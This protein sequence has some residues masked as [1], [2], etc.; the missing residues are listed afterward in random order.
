MIRLYALPISSYSAKVRICLRA[1]GLAFEEVAPPGGY[2]SEDYTALVPVSTIPAIDHDGFVVWDSEA[3]VEYLEEAFP[4]PAML[5]AD[6][7]HRAFARALARFHDTRLEPN[8]RALFPHVAPEN[9]DPERVATSVAMIE[10]RLKQLSA[11][12][13][14]A[15][16]VPGEHLMLCDCGFAISFVLLERLGAAIGFDAP[17]VSSISGYRDRMARHPAVAEVLASYEPAITD[18]ARSRGA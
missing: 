7:Q 3:I 11:V 2:G 6:L 9:R 10:T 12:L 15:P 17:M 5:P 13:D 18:W 1:K 8:I 16:F 4:Q 14:R